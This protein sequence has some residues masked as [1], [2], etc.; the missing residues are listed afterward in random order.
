MST[1][2]GT[3][4]QMRRAHK[5]HWVIAE[6]GRAE[7]WGYELQA[8]DDWSHYWPGGDAEVWG[9]VVKQAELGVAT[10][11]A[12]LSWLAA[13]SPIEF[14]VIAAH[15]LAARLGIPS[16]NVANAIDLALMAARDEA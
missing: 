9:A 10:T 8:D 15:A 16:P 7:G 1:N 4:D 3:A 6:T 11:E 5:N 13:N 12:A 14:A 2:W